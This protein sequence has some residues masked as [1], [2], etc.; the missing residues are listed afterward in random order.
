MNK[1]LKGAPIDLVSMNKI[2]FGSRD[3]D[4]PDE[5][6]PI[7]DEMWNKVKPK[8]SGVSTGKIIIT[9]TP[10][11]MNNSEFFKRWD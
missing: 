6:V 9:S 8:L 11:G 1:K 7:S 3:P 5:C 10:H 4:F 2:V